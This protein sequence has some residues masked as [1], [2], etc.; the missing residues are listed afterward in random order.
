M[1]GWRVGVDIGGTFTDIVFLGADGALHAKKV[2]SSVDNYARAIVAGM[3]AALHE[4]GLSGGDIAEVLAAIAPRKVLAAT[5]TGKPDQKLTN[6]DQ[7][8]K[9]FSA[10]AAVLLDWL[11]DAGFAPPPPGA[12]EDFPERDWVKWWSEA[13]PTWTEEE[14]ARAWKALDRVSFFEV[15]ETELEE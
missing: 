3:T 14:Q 8:D 4:A 2:S 1:S 11:T 12:D 6:L 15:V 7:T 9:R 13:L 10:D 5:P